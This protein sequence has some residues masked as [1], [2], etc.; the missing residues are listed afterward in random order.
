MYSHIAGY[1]DIE[2]VPR[3]IFKTCLPNASTLPIA[4]DQKVSKSFHREHDSSVPTQTLRISEPSPN[5]PSALQH[6]LLTCE[7]QGY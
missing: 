5:E 3:F 4:Q 1:L 2:S 6:S 7:V